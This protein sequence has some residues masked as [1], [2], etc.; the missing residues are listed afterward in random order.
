MKYFVVAISIFLGNASFTQIT[1]GPEVGANFIQVRTNNLGD[2]YHLGFNGGLSAEYI[3]TDHFSVKSGIYFTQKKQSYS[4]ADTNAVEIFGFDL[5]G[6]IPGIKLE[7]YSSISGLVSQSYIQLPIMPTYIYDN[8]SISAGPF[9]GFM[10]RA[11]R[12][13]EHKSE[14]PA[15]NVI[16]L[17]SL[18]PSGL[19]SLLM[20]PASSAEFIETSSKE[21]LR[22]FDYG[23]KTSVA[24]RMDNFAVSFSYLYGLPDYR[25]DRGSSGLQRHSYFQ[26]GMSY[27]FLIGNVKSSS[28]RY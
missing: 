14:I 20:P 15:L 24:Y 21:N 22:I 17:D 6:L 13:E 7:E 18:D 23:F 4:S 9:F 5:Q 2:D 25:I 11:W 16:N 12:K 8:F 3:F 1:I 27:N 26:A 10:L 28:S 19:L